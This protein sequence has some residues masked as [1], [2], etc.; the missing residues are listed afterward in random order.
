[1]KL[2]RI[3]CPEPTVEYVELAKQVLLQWRNIVF[4]RDVQQN[5]KMITERMMMP[6][7]VLETLAEE[8]THVTDPSMIFTVAKWTAR[9]SAI[10]E[11]LFGLLSILSKRLRDTLSM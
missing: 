2:E 1:S 11:E 6:D 8:F 3:R 9:N 4:L 7:I 10:L 5:N